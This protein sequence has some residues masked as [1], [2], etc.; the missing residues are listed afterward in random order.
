MLRR[1]LLPVIIVLTPIMAVSGSTAAR[2]SLV[3]L[4]WNIGNGRFQEPSD[5]PLSMLTFLTS[6]RGLRAR[7]SSHRRR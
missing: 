3:R 1:V 2:S 7:M 5:V 6:V 4:L